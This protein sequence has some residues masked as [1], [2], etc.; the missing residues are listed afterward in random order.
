MFQ[1]HGDTFDLP[2]LATRLAT[3]S[4]CHNQ[5]FKLGKNVY[6]L[7]FHI[8]VTP[9]MITSWTKEYMDEDK[10]EDLSLAKEMIAVAQE[11]KDRY[12]K[13]ANQILSNFT[14]LITQ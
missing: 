11:K 14:Q 3:S 5:A 2:N 6:G 1:W 10:K 9:V 8:E 13:Q 12:F 7:Q 4:V